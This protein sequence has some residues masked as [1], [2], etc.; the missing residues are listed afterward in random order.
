MPNL[1]PACNSEFSH[2]I[3][4]KIIQRGRGERVWRRC[5][6]CRGY[7]DSKTYDRH[8]ELLHAQDRP[9]GRPDSGIRLNDSKIRMFH[10]VLR[11]LQRHCPPPAGILDVGCS[12][13]GFL[14]EARQ[15]GYS[16]AGSDI[17]TGAVEYL[18]S[19]NIPAQRSFSIGD[20]TL[21]EDGDLDVLTCLDCNYYWPD[22]R[23]ELRYAFNKL[24]PGGY[25]AMRVVDKSWLFSFGLAIH[26]ITPR[27][28]H[29]ILCESVNDHRFSMPI[30]SLLNLITNCGFRIVH[31]SPYGAIY[32][33]AAGWTVQLSFAL[34]SLLWKTTGKF[35]APGAIILA[36][37]PVK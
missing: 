32:S 17:V 37:K 1:C 8:E 12:Y 34:G 20:V 15:A 4:V 29:S 14:I 30:R 19:L 22:Q 24:K 25:L 3:G 6:N 23:S 28:A 16:V 5:L 7:F 21:A 18:R 36:R 13:G 11:L 31:A 2:S 10:S 33:K 26:R 35:M 9:S 27:I